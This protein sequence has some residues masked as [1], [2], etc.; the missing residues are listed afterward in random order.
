MTT[1][2]ALSRMLR[3]TADKAHR[4]SQ[5]GY[6]DSDYDVMENYLTVTNSLLAADYEDDMSILPQASEAPWCPESVIKFLQ[7]HAS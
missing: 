4:M 6:T 1:S 5:N 2:E 7:D 3:V